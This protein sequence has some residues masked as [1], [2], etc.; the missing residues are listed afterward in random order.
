MKVLFIYRHK[1][2]FVEKDIE[3][4]K[5]HYDVVPFFF[6]F[7]KLL[8]LRRELKKCDVVFIWF[9]SFHAYITAKMTKKPMIVVTG[10]YDVAGER[11]IRY[12]LMLNPV[13]RHMVKYVL[14]KAKK[15]L[16]VSEFNKGEIEK[17]LGINNAEVIYN[18]IDHNK[19]IPGS[20]KQKII[21][22]V[23]FIKDE[24][25]VR[26]G[27]DTFVEAAQLFNLH[28]IPGRFVVVGKIADSMKERVKHVEKNTP[29]ITFTGFIPDE[30]LL[31]WYQKAKVYC[32]L[33]IYESFGVAP[34]E[35]MACGCVPVVSNRGALPEVVGDVGFYVDLQHLCITE[36][37]ILN[38]LKSRRCK[39]AR[40][41]VIDNFSDEH[42]ERKLKRILDE[43][44]TK[45]I[46]DDC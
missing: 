12:G 3:L 20:K 37:A 39:K 21:L 31:K 7:S 1:R 45:K 34:S 42:R 30:E 4:L 46:S 18:V 44:D 9:A 17:Y 14:K 43:Y 5:K 11:S 19:F 15:I 24:T 23:G 35:A 25:W 13:Y 27:I 16:A 29:N 36:Q 8:Q 32:Q 22:T 26:K 40:K 38:A 10:G 28:E 2:T 33:S 6:S 41:R